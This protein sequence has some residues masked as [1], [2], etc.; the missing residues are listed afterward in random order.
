MIQYLH[1]KAITHL[2][3]V[4]KNYNLAIDLN[5]YLDPTKP[6]FRIYYHL[7]PCF[8]NNARSDLNK[9]YGKWIVK[10]LNKVK[11]PNENIVT[12]KDGP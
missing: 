12:L 11:I 10:G 4:N 3:C 8:I 6:V 5:R 7:T 2:A 1:I 9:K